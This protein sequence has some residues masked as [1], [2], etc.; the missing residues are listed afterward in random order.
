VQCCAVVAFVGVTWFRRH[1]LY[2][3]VPRYIH[4]YT[5]YIQLLEKKELGASELK[6]R[7]FYRS[8]RGE[9]CSKWAVRHTSCKLMIISNWR[10]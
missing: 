2:A 4:S 6:G 9:W 7:A 5:T 1:M 3:C 8:G 10:K